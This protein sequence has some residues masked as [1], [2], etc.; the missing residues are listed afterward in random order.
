MGRGSSQTSLE[1]NP[2]RTSDT[3]PCAPPAAPERRPENAAL[4]PSTQR[5]TDAAPRPARRA[6]RG[7]FDRGR[8]TSRVGP[9]RRAASA[10]RRL[11]TRARRRLDQASCKARLRRLPAQPGR[12]RGPRRH[13]LRRSRL[14]RLPRGLRAK[15]RQLGFWRASSPSSRILKCTTLGATPSLRR[16]RP[17]L[18]SGCRR[19]GKAIRML[20]SPRERIGPSRPNQRTTTSPL[21]SAAARPRGPRRFARRRACRRRR[22]TP[23]FDP[24][25]ARTRRHTRQRPSTALGPPRARPKTRPRRPKP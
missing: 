14:A 17:R 19:R 16:P 12:A 2:G 9:R 22:Q 15:M 18:W 25:L 21:R 10:R 5:S 20:W 11:P 1:T 6:R 24:S 3:S 23:R 4:F 7:T 13:Q 8:R